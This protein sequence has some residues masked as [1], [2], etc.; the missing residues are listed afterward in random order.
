MN[1]HPARVLILSL[2]PMGF[3]VAL[4]I[5]GIH[6]STT[7]TRGITGLIFGLALSIVLLPVLEEFVD[8]FLTRLLTLAI[9]LDE[10]NLRNLQ[11]ALNLRNPS[12]QSR[13]DH[14]TETR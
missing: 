3:D 13:I 7:M 10:R 11:S 12:N 4:A 2:V 5:F 8:K 6:E 14:A 1:A 9:T